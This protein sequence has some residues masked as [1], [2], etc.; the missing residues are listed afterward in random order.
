MPDRE[1][2]Q[3]FSNVSYANEAAVEV[4]HDVLKL[5]F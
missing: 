3:L 4:G 5:V 2:E 1:C